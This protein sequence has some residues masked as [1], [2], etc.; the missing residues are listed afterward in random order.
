MLFFHNLIVE[1]S[2]QDAIKFPKGLIATSFI[3]FLWAINF[4]GLELGFNLN[5]ITLP[6][7]LPV[8]I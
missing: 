6:S 2:E 7:S 8:I 3:V 4:I 1:S 5:N